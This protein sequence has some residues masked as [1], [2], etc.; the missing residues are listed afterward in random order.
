M[1]SSLSSLVDNL[2]ERIQSDKFT[3]CKSCLT[4]WFSRMTDYSL[5]ILS[6][7]RIIRMTLIKN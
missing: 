5:G 4:I 7:K 3:G 2:S 6:V 1:S